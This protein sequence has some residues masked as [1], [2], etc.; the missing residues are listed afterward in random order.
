MSHV[1]AAVEKVRHLNESQAE[2]LL[3]WIESRQSREVLRNRL[4]QEIAV[5]L[6][7]LQRG[8]KIPGDQVHAEIRERSRLRRTGQNG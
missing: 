6:D 2:A 1:E 5:G 7:Q 4:D 8:E 3:E